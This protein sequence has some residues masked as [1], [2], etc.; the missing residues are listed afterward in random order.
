M[1]IKS[2]VTLSSVSEKTRDLL[3]AHGIR[4]EEFDFSSEK[5][6]FEGIQRATD[7]I[8]KFPGP[9]LVHCTAGADR[10]GIV[11]AALRTRFGE[12]DADKLFKEMRK[13]CHVTF[14]KYRYYYELL[15]KFMEVRSEK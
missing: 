8:L 15:D 1:G 11:I 10:T 6:T 14:K 3:K 2:I 12:K 5:M 9:V 13:Y 7:A 4:H